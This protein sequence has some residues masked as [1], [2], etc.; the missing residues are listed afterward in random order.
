MAFFIH[1][2]IMCANPSYEAYD[3][4]VNVRYGMVC[5]CQLLYFQQ[6]GFCSRVDD[7]S[8]VW[9]SNSYLHFAFMCSVIT[10]TRASILLAAAKQI[11]SRFMLTY[12]AH[13]ALLLHHLTRDVLLPFSFSSLL[14]DLHLR[15]PDYKI[16]DLQRK[17]SAR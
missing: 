2:Y 13:Q 4:T 10:H 1:I 5:I 6:S 7:I 9:T 17:P 16:K 11:H 12:C 3:G 15:P 8:G 14:I